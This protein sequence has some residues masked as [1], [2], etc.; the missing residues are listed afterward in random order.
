MYTNLRGE[1]REVQDSDT[2]IIFDEHK[3]LEIVDPHGFFYFANVTV[4]K[5]NTKY[6]V[7]YNVTFTKPME[8]SDIIFRIW[9]DR[10]NVA[11]TKIFDAW[12]VVG[13]EIKPEEQFSLLLSEPAVKHVE[14]SEFSLYDKE[15]AIIM[16]KWAG[17]YA[18]SASDAFMLK[19]LG[20]EG[21]HIPHWAKKFFG[22][23][24]HQ[25][26]L[27]MNDFVEAIKYLSKVGIVK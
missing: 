24:I 16:D 4:H 19:A 18:E 21:N 26:D 17:Y 6:I 9:D 10:R 11:D 25:G 8:K 27:E 15:A 14:S 5:N 23:N 12:Q 20:L 7:S 13:E 2:Y 1:K 22:E 3:E